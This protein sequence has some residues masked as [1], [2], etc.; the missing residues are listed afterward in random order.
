MALEWG[1]RVDP[2]FTSEHTSAFK[3]AELNNFNIP[4]IGGPVSPEECSLRMEA[5]KPA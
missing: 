1:S 3:S 4:S 2:N 5:A